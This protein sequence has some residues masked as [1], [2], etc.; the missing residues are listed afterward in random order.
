MARQ[1][2]PPEEMSTV[3]Y[4]GPRVSRLRLSIPAITAAGFF[5]LIFNGAPA[6]SEPLR[7][8]VVSFQKKSDTPQ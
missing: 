1:P 2:H 7:F 5:Q 6:N 3:S 8:A 4:Q